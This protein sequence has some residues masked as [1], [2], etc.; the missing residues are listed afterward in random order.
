VKFTKSQCSCELSCQSLLDSHM[1]GRDGVEKR[2][3]MGE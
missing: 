1:K 3:G 2:C